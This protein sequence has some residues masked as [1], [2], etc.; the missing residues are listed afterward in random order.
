M[1]TLEIMWLMFCDYADVIGAAFL[2]AII[3]YV[4]GFF[5]NK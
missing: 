1:I 2:L 4:A 3:I 5:S